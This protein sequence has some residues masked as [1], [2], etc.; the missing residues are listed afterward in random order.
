MSCEDCDHEGEGETPC[1][2]G[3]DGVSL[4]EIDWEKGHEPSFQA[5]RQACAAC[6]RLASLPHGKEHS[7]G[8]NCVVNGV[9]MAKFWAPRT[10]DLDNSSVSDFWK[11]TR[12][13]PRAAVGTAG[14][15]PLLTGTPIYL[16]NCALLI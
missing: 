4:S 6:E 14:H 5:A 13:P 8:C 3:E 12:E 1:A 15:L 2:D 9:G 7:R 10:N 11:M 16:L